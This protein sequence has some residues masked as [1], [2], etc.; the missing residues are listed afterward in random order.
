MVLELYAAL[1]EI[2]TQLLFRLY[3]LL[4]GVGQVT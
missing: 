1:Q 2:A 3:C 4:C